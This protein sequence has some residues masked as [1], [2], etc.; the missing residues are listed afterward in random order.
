VEEGQKMTDE[1]VAGVKIIFDLQNRV[2]DVDF[3]KSPERA[4]WQRRFGVGPDQDRVIR[5]ISEDQ[6][7]LVQAFMAKAEE[8]GSATFLG[9][10]PIDEDE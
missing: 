6:L 7:S 10:R 1:S 3:S 4:L 5:V 9:A 2:M 8:E